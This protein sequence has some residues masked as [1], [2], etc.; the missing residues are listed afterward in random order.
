MARRLGIILA[1]TLVAL[2]VMTDGAWACR[3]M[4]R[5]INGCGYRRA[6]CRI[7]LQPICCQTAALPG[8]CQPAATEMKP[9]EGSPKAAS[10]V[11][12]DP[13]MPPAPAADAK[14]P[15]T[16]AEP[17]KEKPAEP[18]PEPKLDP[19]PDPAPKPEPPAKAG[20]VEVPAEQRVTPKPDLV[21]MDPVKPA[22]PVKLPDVP[23]PAEKAAEA[24]KPETPQ[25]EI[26][27]PTAPKAGAAI[28]DS[29]KPD[30]PTPVP[31]PVAPKAGAATPD[32]S[33]PKPGAA[34]PD[35]PFGDGSSNDVKTLRMWTDA[36]GQYQLEA[37]FV[38]FQDGTVRLQKANGGYVRIAYDLLSASDRDFVLHQDGSM[39]AQQ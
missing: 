31:T 21:P 5:L 9:A 13:S 16:P 18:K 23:K 3:C 1:T 8:C 17:K 19:K 2:L 34:K 15:E 11:T 26:P 4:N 30:E 39:M 29:A 12:N 25:P 28:P 14:K 20:P 33:K 10:P 36:S 37:R 6:C 7:L 35:D 32:T 38:S 27:T 22:E 24:P